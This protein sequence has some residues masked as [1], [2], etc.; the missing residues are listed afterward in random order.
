[1][2]RLI[3]HSFGVGLVTAKTEP[4]QHTRIMS[5]SQELVAKGHSCIAAAAKAYDL[6]Y[7]E[8]NAKDAEKYL[9]ALKEE[10]EQ[11]QKA[12]ED[13]KED[14]LEKE[15]TLRKEMALLEAEE[16]RFESA[17]SS[18]TNSK[19]SAEHKL[20]NHV[21]ALGDSRY[22]QSQSEERLRRAESELSSAIG[23]EAGIA[24]ASVAGGIV[25]GL[26]T[27]GIGGLAVGAVAAG[28]T[29]GIVI[30]CEGK[31][32]DAK[33]DISRCVTDLENCHSNVRSTRDGISNIER[34]IGDYQKRIQVNKEN[35]GKMHQKISG[36]IKSIEFSERSINYWEDF[37]TVSKQAT[38]RSDRLNALVK[39]A[40]AKENF[41]IMTSNGTVII[42]ESFVE[43]WEEVSKE[44]Q[45]MPS[46]DT[47]I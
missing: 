20:Q 22:Q 4:S 7:T 32:K 25:L 36:I 14:L 37:T 8:S 10:G 6:I 42:A 2:L 34:D 45:I 1:M 21:R 44:G 9:A 28:A 43:A 24:T 23:K 47:C 19:S 15:T 13:T 29:A 18:L 41:R 27:F 46:L 26:L 38:E 35:A 5:T 16:Q 17:V 30:A 39:K 33:S 31:V 40:T 3:P 11:L 12:A